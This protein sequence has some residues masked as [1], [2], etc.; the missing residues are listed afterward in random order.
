MV[1]KEVELD[2]FLNQYCDPSFFTQDGLNEIHKH[3]SILEMDKESLLIREGQLS[4][5]VFYLISGAVRS[6][7]IKDGV[8]VNTGFSFEGE[9]EGSFQNFLNKP[10]KETLQVME[11]CRLISI[12]MNTLRPLLKSNIQVSNFVRIIIEEY[13]AFLEDRLFSLQYMSSMERY[14]YLIESNP[15][16]FQRIP[17]TYIA[18]YL[19][20]T[21]ET[22]S[23]LRAKTIL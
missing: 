20:I 3:L 1:Q 15:E 17:L 9:M 7:Y 18:S 12:N 4:N 22:L 8:E 16:I 14:L 13:T 10:S 11:K 23:R 5:Y 2:K 19:G 6:F 21:R